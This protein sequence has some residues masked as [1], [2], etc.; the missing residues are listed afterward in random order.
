MKKTDEERIEELTPSFRKLLQSFLVFLK[1]VV[2]ALRG[3]PIPSRKRK[4]KQRR[5]GEDFTLSPRKKRRR[6]RA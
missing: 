4:K 5:V 2:L 6:P 3:Y 1:Q